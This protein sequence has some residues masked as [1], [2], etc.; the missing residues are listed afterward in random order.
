MRQVLSEYSI[1]TPNK[2]V[3]WERGAND[4]YQV[5][6]DHTRYFLRVYRHGAFPRQAN[7][8]EVEALNYLHQNGISVA[9][10]IPRKSGGYL[11]EINAPEGPRLALL[12]ALAEGSEPDYDSADV[13]HTVGQ[14]VA[15]MHTASS[16]FTTKLKRSNLGL[17]GLFDDSIL[18][19][20]SFLADRRDA[21]GTIEKISQETRKA[22]SNAPDE[23][24]DFGICH[25]DMHG[26]NMHIDDSQQVTFFDFE[27]CAFGY[28]V[29][30][31]A[32]LKWGTSLGNDER[33]AQRWPALLEGYESVRPLSHVEKSLVD[34]FMILRE[35]AEAAY[36]IKHVRDFGHN[37]IMASDIDYVCHRLKKMQSADS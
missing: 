21:M 19:I 29:Y 33:R 1:D 20:R 10:P 6:C 22:I 17:N 36:G 14:S 15:K 11:T 24:L 9:Y 4:T 23:S 5:Y 37:G 31:L 35:L 2:C 27:E 12:T 16:G 26:G 28:R 13:C 32:T 3:F 34:S 25:G 18:T 8:F 7:E 30:D